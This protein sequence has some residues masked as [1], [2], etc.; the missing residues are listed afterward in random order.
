MAVAV[1]LHDLTLASRFCTQVCVLQ[2]GRMVVQGAPHAVL[3]D[4][5]LQRVFNLQVLRMDQS[6]AS[7]V[8]PWEVFA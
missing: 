4:D 2:Q 8:V 3:D 1:V 5:L 7:C 6:G